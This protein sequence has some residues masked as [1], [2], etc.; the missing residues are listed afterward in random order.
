MSSVLLGISPVSQILINQ[1]LSHNIQKEANTGTRKQ[2][3]SAI[4]KGGI[5][6][7]HIAVSVKCNKGHVYGASCLWEVS[8]ANAPSNS[9]I[10]P[11]ILEQL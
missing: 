9:L 7:S 11:D 5:I 10:T 2:G 3:L 4:R 1:N 8:S 6:H